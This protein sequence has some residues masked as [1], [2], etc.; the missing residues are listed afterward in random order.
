MIL[1]KPAIKGTAI[2]TTCSLIYIA[3]DR[4]KTLSPYPKGFN[5]MIPKWYDNTECGQLYQFSDVKIPKLVVNDDDYKA[6][7]FPEPNSII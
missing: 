2:Y 4:H 3:Q 6:D 1:F 7:A 5:F